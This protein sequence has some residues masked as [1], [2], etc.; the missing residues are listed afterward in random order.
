M[1]PIPLTRPLSQAAPREWFPRPDG[2]LTDGRR[3][4]RVVWQLLDGPQL[5][6]YSLEDCTTLEVE[7][8]LPGELATMGLRPV[9]LA[10]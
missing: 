5:G 10:A 2:Y 7:T 6:F 9:Q 3:L 8:Y 1:A 4:F